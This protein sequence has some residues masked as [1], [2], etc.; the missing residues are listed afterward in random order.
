MSFEDVL[1]LL[2]LQ[3]EYAPPLPLTQALNLVP[4]HEL[5]RAPL[6]R[7]GQQDLAASAN[8]PALSLEIRVDDCMCLAGPD[9][10]RRGWVTVRGCPQTVT[11]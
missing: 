11:G 8:D 1:A 6:Q 4:G 2:L 9:C 7:L 3:Q 5:S 10:M